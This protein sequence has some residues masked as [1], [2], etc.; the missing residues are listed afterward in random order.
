MNLD[1]N[2]TKAQ[3]EIFFNQTAKYIIATKGRRF[4]AT[5]GASQAFIEFLLEGISP[6]LWVDTVNGNIDRYYERYFLP[7]LKKLP[8][9]ITWNFNRQKRELNILGR[10]ID[11]R[12][13]DNPENIEGFG[14]KKI[15]LNEAG[16]ILKNDY[17]YTN[18]ILPLL[19][20]YPDSQLIAAGVPKGMYKK[21]GSEHKF[22][23]LYKQ[24][25]NNLNG[26]YKLLEYTSFD[27][28]Y[29]RREDIEKLQEEYM[30]LGYTQYEQEVL[31]KFVEVAPGSNPF[32]IS[33]KP[34]KHESK[35][36]VYNPLRQTL[37]SID[38]NLD[39]FTVVFAQAWRDS[40]GDHFHIINELEIQGGSIPVLIEALYAKQEEMPGYLRSCLITGDAMGKQ[41]DISQRDN[42][43]HYIK[44]Q[45]GLR[46]HNSHFKVPSNPRHKNSRSDC[47]FVLYH[48]PDF[49]INPKTCP[50]TAKD[51]KIVQADN[52][53][54]I[55]KS[56]RMLEEQKADF[57]DNVRYLINTF[58]HKWIE[59]HD[60]MQIRMG[61]KL[62]E[63]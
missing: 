21:D 17:L 35:E 8:P 60:K 14:Y 15:F 9:E 11:F 54:N 57:L 18:S 41:R 7:I 32:M 40:T 63:Q 48:H 20:D 52:Q 36:V 42:A 46:L 27:N 49:K 56:N 6:L 33:Y 45:R 29:L 28:P 43:S 30:L 24:A 61:N 25:K 53:G 38:F 22:Y 31:G 16:I 47:N 2:Y 13:A 10:I 44:L 39:P 3:T 26:S 59:R 19:L 12:S 37:V 4:G 23:T 58:L 51:M 55:I 50:K 34:T 5:R 1:L 62:I